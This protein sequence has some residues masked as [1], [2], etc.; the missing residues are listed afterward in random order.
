ML[1][2][3]LFYFSIGLIGISVLVLF[4]V[5]KKRKFTP[6]EKIQSLKNLSEL[7]TAEY[8]VT[9]IVKY[10]NDNFFGDRKILFETTAVL[11]AGVDLANLQDENFIVKKDSITLLLPAP[12]LLSLNMHSDSI[13]QRFIK[14]GAFRS[15][16]SNKDIDKILA[17]GEKSIRENVEGIG[18]I[19]TARENTKIFLETW[20]HIS[21][22]KFVSIQ[23]LDIEPKT[24]KKQ[25]ETH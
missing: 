3:R 21:G 7:A 10:N 25:D 24:D 20:L 16:F 2:R 4:F 14:S 22:F 1:M 15:A 18:I 17:E 23:F 6:A 19:E 5:P 9:K 8:V 13:K 12:Q 11:K